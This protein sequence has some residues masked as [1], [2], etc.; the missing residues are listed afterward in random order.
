[1]KHTLHIVDELGEQ[2]F[3]QPV[4]SIESV[5]RSLRQRL[6]PVERT[7]RNR[8]HDEER[9]Q[10]DDQYGEKCKQYSLDDVLE[11]LSSPCFESDIDVTIYRYKF[12]PILPPDSIFMQ[13]DSIRIQYFFQKIRCCVR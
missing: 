3:V 11:Q 12:I 5:D 7:A 4:T 1:M 2:R 10:A 9:D 8:V 6:L 13:E